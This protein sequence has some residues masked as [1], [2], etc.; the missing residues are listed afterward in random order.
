MWAPKPGPRSWT[1]TTHTSD[2][3]GQGSEAARTCGN[4]VSCDDTLWTFRS[5]TRTAGRRNAG[6]AGV[7]PAASMTSGPW[8]ARSA[9]RSHQRHLWGRRL[10]HTN[11]LAVIAGPDLPLPAARE[12]VVN[13]DSRD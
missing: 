5:T 12:R 2:R 7:A 3:P 11:T 9:G 13:A 4:V 8:P 10:R 1:A 6:S